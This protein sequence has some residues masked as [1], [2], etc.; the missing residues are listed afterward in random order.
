[1]NFEGIHKKR[2]SAEKMSLTTD[3]P[4]G[5]STLTLVPFLNLHNA[6]FDNRL[7]QLQFISSNLR[8]NTN[9]PS[10]S[11]LNLTLANLRHT[12]LESKFISKKLV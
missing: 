12:I 9:A 5:K 3:I 6:V 8:L 2:I 10:N 4:M 11:S 1:M 7:T